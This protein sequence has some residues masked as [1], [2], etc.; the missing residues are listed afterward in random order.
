[1][2]DALSPARK[3]F[4]LGAV[5]I[6]LVA[7][8]VVGVAAWTSRDEAVRPVSQETPGPV[9][10]VPGYGGGTAALEVLADALRA[11]GRQVVVVDLPGDNSGDLDEQ[12]RALDKAVVLQMQREGARSVDVVGYS[13][14]GVVA[15]L[16]AREHGGGSLARRI[17]TIG[18][19]HHGT[20]LA[21]LGA[22]VAPD[23]CPEACQQ[24]LPDSEL[25]RKLNAGDETPAGPVW[26]SIWTTDDRIVV[27]PSSADLDGALGFTIQSVC[28]AR[29]RQPRRPPAH[30]L[31][32]RGRD[33]RAG[34][35][36]ARTVTRARTIC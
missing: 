15:R 20:D 26:V 17:V 16:W 21:G 7:A 22:D 32:H 25:L 3:R 11:Q 28:P 30:A 10:L 24:L 2:L 8:T 33:P 31:D 36:G 19:P 12:A 1:M 27:P 18:S 5:L 23:S 6:A 4:V 34:R 29:G 14:G 13:A 9:L 35:R